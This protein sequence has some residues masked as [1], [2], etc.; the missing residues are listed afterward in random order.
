MKKWGVYR[1][2]DDLAG[3]RPGVSV[4]YCLESWRGFW[5]CCWFNKTKTYPVFVYIV[6]FNLE[7]FP[8]D[9]DQYALNAN[10]LQVSCNQQFD[11]AYNT[12]AYFSIVT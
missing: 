9:L 4:S 6:V 12:G 10:D 8:A 3:I 7:R 11:N 2:D 5:C 1:A